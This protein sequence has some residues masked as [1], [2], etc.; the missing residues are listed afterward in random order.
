M[1]DDL[2]RSVYLALIALGLFAISVSQLFP[3]PGEFQCR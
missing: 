1:A 2:Y 3:L